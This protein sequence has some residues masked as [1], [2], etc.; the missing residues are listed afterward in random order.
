MKTRMKLNEI[1][2]CQVFNGYM[3][4]VITMDSTGRTFPSSQIIFLESTELD[5][6]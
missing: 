2:K 6:L 5:N 3:W 1:E 4:L